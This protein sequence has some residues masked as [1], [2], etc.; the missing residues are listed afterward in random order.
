MEGIEHINVNQ[1]LGKKKFATPNKKDKVKKTVVLG[2]AGLFIGFVNGLFGAGGGMLAVPLLTVVAGL[3]TKRSH[4]TAIL[5]ILPLCLVSAVIYL[6][7]GVYDK[8]VFAP[9]ILGVVIGGL[10]GAYALKKCSNIA[11]QI[12]FY[13]VM[14]LA[15]LKMIF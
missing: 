7:K 11:L 6:S 4:A 2:V 10:M 14:L 15:G 12:L 1:Y 5:V 8:D 3:N 13:G 9:T